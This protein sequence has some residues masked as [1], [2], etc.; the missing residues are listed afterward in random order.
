MKTLLGFLVVALVAV[1]IWFGI[2]H[3]NLIQKLS[4]ETNITSG[5]VP[6]TQEQWQSEVDAG[7]SP[8]QIIQ[9][10][11]IRK[12]KQPCP[13]SDPAG[14][15]TNCTATTTGNPNNPLGI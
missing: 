2:D 3:H 15:F 1:S 10:E 8:Q 9:F 13:T 6:L 14:L 4:K 11:K 7:F 5:F 12:A